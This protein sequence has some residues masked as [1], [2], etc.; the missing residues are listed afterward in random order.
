LAAVYASGGRG[1]DDDD[2]DGGAGGTTYVDDRDDDRMDDTIEGVG[3]VG[4]GGGGRGGRTRRGGGRGR[5]RSRVGVPA[6]F[7]G[8][9]SSTK[10]WSNGY[11]AVESD[12][13]M[14]TSNGYD[15][16]RRRE[17]MMEGE[18]DDD[19]DDDECT[20]EYD[21][22]CRD[23]DGDDYH[24]SNTIL[25]KFAYH[26]LYPPHVP[27]SC[28]LYRLE[29]IAIPYCYLLVG[30]LQGLSG[31]FVNVYPL[32]LGASE[33]QQST[34]SSLRSLP[35]SFKLIFGFVS[36]NLPLCGYRRK[37]YM[38]MGWGIASLSM[39]ILLAMSDLTMDAVE[40][41]AST[42]LRQGGGSGD[43]DDEN[44]RRYAMTMEGMGGMTT[45]TTTTMETT[46]SFPD[47]YDR[48]LT[49][50]EGMHGDDVGMPPSIPLLSIC[51]LLFGTGFWIADVMGDSLV[52]EK[53][54]LEPTSSRGQLQSSCYAC[55]FFGLMISA[56]VG[57]VMY[58]SSSPYL[59]PRGLVLLLAI[60]PASIVPLILCLGEQRNAR[61]PSTA[62]QCREIWYTVCSRAV[63][64]PMGFVYLYNVLQVGNAAWK[65]FLKTVLG[66]TSNQLNSL[67]IV[68]YV[69]LWLGIVAYKRY[70]IHWS[71]RT[72]YVLTTVLNGIFS[73][74][75][76]LLI[77]GMTFGLS[78]YLFALGDDAFADFIAGIQFLPTTIMMV[79]LC[80][81]GSEG[82]SYAMFTTVNNSA[83]NLAGAMS[84]LLLG[85]WD[86][87]K[88]AM[89]VGNLVGMINLTWL[90]T[91]IQM[92]GLLFVGL[93]P[94]TKED[95]ANLHADPMS[96]SRIGGFVFLF[97][98]FSSVLYSLIV[99]VLNIVRPGWAGES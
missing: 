26:Y 34:I 37:S 15:H 97:V 1:C 19:D 27:R 32:D 56:P 36:D 47:G 85:V 77:K 79:H 82:A 2:D 14:G 92:S 57:T 52:A 29:N 91:A 43:G 70:F 74:L 89:E 24:S 13:A 51:L 55:R 21:D 25:P 54:K 44:M 90:T 81:S 84:T 64:Q 78:P 58:G 8:G 5:Y 3:G 18:D 73:S 31:P 65:Q 33:A 63:W 72:I 46:T 35:A 59:G 7:L 96:G 66:F 40:N 6:I 4:V 9:S 38:L 75:Q 68:A 60:L 95:L 80:P 12:G 62:D 23:V 50:D 28:Q 69:L 30:L 86:V 61:V 94:R 49:V 22:V 83:G 11:D 42:R 20:G 87:S 39:L 53:A 71:W 10:S 99:G 16:A 67:L 45:M 17:M 41:Y 48:A 88:G 93:L 76:V 98:T